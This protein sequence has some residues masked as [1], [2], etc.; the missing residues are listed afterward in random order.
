MS[1]IIKEGRLKE[2]IK[3]CPK[4]GCQFG[5][6]VRDIWKESD[7]TPYHPDVFWIKCPYCHEHLKLILSELAKVDGDSD[8]MEDVR[9]LAK[10]YG[11]ELVNIE[12]K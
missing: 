1:R 2:Q 9:A 10:Q 8:F 12:V 3:T 7:C 6:D 4:C 11:Y 5:Y